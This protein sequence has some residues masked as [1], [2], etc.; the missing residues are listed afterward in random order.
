MRTKRVVGAMVVVLMVA[1][2]PAAAFA[3]SARHQARAARHLSTSPKSPHQGQWRGRSSQGTREV[4]NVLRTRKG[5][6]IQPW[7]L[8]FVATCS[9]SGAQVGLGF[10]G[11]SQVLGKDGSFSF[12]FFD[13]FFGSF[14]F[15]GQLGQT[16]GTGTG[17]I[18][19]PAL[20]KKGG[21]ELCSSG[22]VSW[23][24]SSPGASSSPS[25]VDVAYH[26]QL[27]QAPSG[28]VSWTVTKG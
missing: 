8:E 18:S 28:K 2:T 12:H 22:S 3:V 4:F 25:A 7:D 26:I 24:A 9:S 20:V 23:K 27:T 16:T 19:L 11:G 5:L 13:P 17:S 15:Q 6:T 10:G 14:D 21:T 1:A